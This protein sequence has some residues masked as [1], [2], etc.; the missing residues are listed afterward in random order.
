M[1][2]TITRVAFVDLAVLNY[3]LD[4]V[5]KT[6]GEDFEFTTRIKYEKLILEGKLNIYLEV[7]EKWEEEKNEWSWKFPFYTIV[8]VE[9][10]RKRWVHS[11]RFEITETTLVDCRGDV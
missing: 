6:L 7:H 3:V 11:N 8:K 10:S 9:R 1:A 5:V 2:N 4:Y